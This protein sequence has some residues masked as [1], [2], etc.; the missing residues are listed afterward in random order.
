VLLPFRIDVLI[1]YRSVWMRLLA[2]VEGPLTGR[3]TRT[4]PSEWE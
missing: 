1:D 3:C 4:D 2:P